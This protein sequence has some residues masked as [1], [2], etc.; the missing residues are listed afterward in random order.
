MAWWVVKMQGLSLLRYV[1]VPPLENYARL[2]TLD[3]QSSG[4]STGILRRRCRRFS[5]RVRALLL[6]GEARTFSV[7]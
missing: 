7:R 4:F 1:T 6:S 2:D 5:R 3:G